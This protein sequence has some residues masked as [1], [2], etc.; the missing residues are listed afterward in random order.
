MKRFGRFVG[1]ALILVMT[2]VVARNCFSHDLIVRLKDRKEIPFNEMVTDL[3]GAKVIYVGETHDNPDHHD[4]QLRIIRELHRA[5]VPLAIGME[6]FTAE[7][8]KELDR[9]VAG[10]TDKGAF[11]R[12]YLKNWN[13]PWA[14][15]GDILLFARDQRIP[16][17]GLNVPREVTRKVARQGFESLSPQERRQLPPDITC[18]VD[19]AY[20]AMIRR[21]YSDHDTSAKTFKNFCEAQML[22]NKSMAYNMLEYIKKSPRRTV[23]VIAGSGHAIR[24]GMPVQVDR[25]KPG[26]ASRVVLP[27]PVV[28]NGSITVADA[29]Y[30]WLSH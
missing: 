17:I 28:Q 30:L 26:L 4:L 15:Y 20:M 9:W 19:G 27:D 5:G 6:M 3:K 14:I 18:D 23:V 12:I 10:K 29:D 2:A 1:I 21:S 8:Q 22:W 7:S 25:E 16:L 24:G 13:L 11:Q